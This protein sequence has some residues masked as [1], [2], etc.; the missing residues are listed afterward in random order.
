M[1]PNVKSKIALNIIRQKIYTMPDSTR[2]WSIYTNSICSLIYNT[3]ILILRE[4]KKFYVISWLPKVKKNG[5]EYTLLEKIYND[6][7]YFVLEY[8]NKRR[9]LSHVKYRNSNLTRIEKI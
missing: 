3:E 7:F 9:M 6:L 4:S 8:I 1:H 2:F 5:S